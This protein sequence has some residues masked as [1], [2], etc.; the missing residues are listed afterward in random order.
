[1]PRDAFP[2]VVE[3]YTNRLNQYAGRVTVL[4]SSVY[5]N[6]TVS[7]SSTFTKEYDGYWTEL[8]TDPDED[9][10]YLINYQN[11]DYLVSGS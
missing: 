11:H 4:G 9:G 2:D 6:I 8:V 3:W 5:P 1:M 7:V 10:N